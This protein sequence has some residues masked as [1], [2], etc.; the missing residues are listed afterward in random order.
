[1]VVVIGDLP[2]EFSAPRDIPNEQLLP[3]GEATDRGYNYYVATGS[4]SPQSSH[5]L[6]NEEAYTVDSREYYN[7]AL[8]P[9][10]EY[11]YFLRIYSKHVRRML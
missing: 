10:Q 9:D 3:Y 1:M 7:A 5:I 4:D 11:S 2:S 8:I 6:G